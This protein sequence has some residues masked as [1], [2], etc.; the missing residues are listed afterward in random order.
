MKGIILIIFLFFGV[1]VWAQQEDNVFQKSENQA[2]GVDSRKGVGDNQVQ[3]VGGLPGDEDP[4][5]APIDN[6]I[7]V[8]II[9]GI[10]LVIYQCKKRQKAI[11]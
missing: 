4:L 5:P 6:Y 11:Q 9:A 8:L 3:K 10:S 1:G 2:T 7:P